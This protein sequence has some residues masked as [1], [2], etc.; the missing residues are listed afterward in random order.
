MSFNKAERDFS[1]T[2]KWNDKFIGN[3]SKITKDTMI[4]D[5]QYDR[6]LIYFP[7]GKDSVKK[8]IFSHKVGIVS[9]EF[10]KGYTIMYK[11]SK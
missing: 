11:K 8:V 3:Y 10:Q 9:A 5:L 1:P 6:V 2:I 4:N 7:T